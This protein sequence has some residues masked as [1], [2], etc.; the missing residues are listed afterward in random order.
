MSDI[1]TGHIYIII[2]IQNPKIYYIGST[3]NLITQRWN[4]HKAHYRENKRLCAICKYFDEY[5]VDNFTIKLLKS[6]DVVRT[7][8][9]DFKHLRAYEQLWM[10]KLKGSCNKVNPLSLLSKQQISK[11]YRE[12]NRDK[13]RESKKQHYQENKTEINKKQRE[14]YQENKTEILE[15]QKEYNKKNKEK[16]NERQKEYNKQNKEKISERKKEYREKNKTEIKAR[17][18][19]KITCECGLESRRSDIA[20][21]RKSQRHIRLMNEK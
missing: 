21:H 2:C 1:S 6:Y 17:Q 13:I 9:K 14:N 12:D 10:N 4:K 5:G 19:E 15:K 20:T 11:F 3:F 7:H 18:S 8:S 16:I